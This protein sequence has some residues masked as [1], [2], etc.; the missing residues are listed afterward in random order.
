MSVAVVQ[1]L[2]RHFRLPFAAAAEELREDVEMTPTLILVWLHWKSLLFPDI[3][4]DWC[5]THFTLMHDTGK[6]YNV[7]D[8]QKFLRALLQSAVTSGKDPSPKAKLPPAYLDL[9]ATS[10]LIDSC[11]RKY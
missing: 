4:Y 7:G 1:K 10:S 2:A 6:G 3:F 5:R 11:T 8:P 9:P